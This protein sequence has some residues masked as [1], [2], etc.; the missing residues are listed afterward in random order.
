ML[1]LHPPPVTLKM[2]TACSFL[3]MEIHWIW[4]KYQFSPNI[5]SFMIYFGRDYT[6]LCLGSSIWTDVLP[7]NSQ[8][9]LASLIHIC[10][11][12][13][14]VAVSLEQS[15]LQPC[16]ASPPLVQSQMHILPFWAA[17]HIPRS[18]AQGPSTSRHEQGCC[19]LA[20]QQ[21]WTLILL[22]ELG[23]L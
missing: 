1:G 2:K 5:S 11:M 6:I 4:R 16:P 9:A 7:L 13:N 18:F 10:R 23:D 22:L 15:A 21:A 3:F 17:V 20:S 14:W 12:A 8:D 19:T